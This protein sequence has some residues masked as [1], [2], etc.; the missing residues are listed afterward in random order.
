MFCVFNT[1]PLKF[2]SVVPSPLWIAFSVVLPLSHRLFTVHWCSGCVTGLLYTS[3]GSL[4]RDFEP[5][6]RATAF[7]SRCFNPGSLLVVFYMLFGVFGVDF[8]ATVW[9]WGCW[10]TSCAFYDV[11]V[12]VFIAISFSCPSSNEIGVIFDW[13]FDCH[14]P[15]R[16]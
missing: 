7:L 5:D 16:K 14:K 8:H 13:T 6:H 12:T 10:L 1:C 9:G 3:I 2:S 4:D 15:Y 11:S